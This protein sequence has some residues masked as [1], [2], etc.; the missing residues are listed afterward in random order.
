MS[1]ELS[2][3]EYPGKAISSSGND[4]N[5]KDIINAADLSDI[6]ADEIEESK[7]ALYRAEVTELTPVE[8]FKWNVDSDQ[9]PC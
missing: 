3:I 8:A 9:S 4:A 6:E 7:E 5:G 1:T 2:Q